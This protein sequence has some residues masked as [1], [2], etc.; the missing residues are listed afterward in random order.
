MEIVS[1]KKNSKCQFEGCD[2]PATDIAAGR[3]NY[4]GVKVYC[5]IHARIVANDGDPEYTDSCPNCD[6]M[7][8]IN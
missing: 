6:C 7:F 1:V 5:K 4:P 8:G 2:K 3:H